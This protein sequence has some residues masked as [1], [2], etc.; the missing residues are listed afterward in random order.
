MCH[1][2]VNE[3]FKVVGERLGES[4]PGEK[5][6]PTF[7]KNCVVKCLKISL[8]QVVTAIEFLSLSN[9]LSPHAHGTW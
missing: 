9:F 1:S 3:C 4:P 5:K 2:H 6:Y 7:L 8:S